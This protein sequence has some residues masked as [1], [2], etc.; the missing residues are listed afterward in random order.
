MSLYIKPIEDKKSSPEYHRHKTTT[1]IYDSLSSFL[2]PNIFWWAFRV[3]NSDE[4]AKTWKSFFIDYE[5]FQPEKTF[6][7]EGG[8]KLFILLPFTVTNN[9]VDLPKH[10]IYCDKK[11]FMMSVHV[12]TITNCYTKCCSSFLLLRVGVCVSTMETERENVFF[13]N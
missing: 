1:I 11:K 9:F 6:M 2:S 12:D 3:W 7:M 5:A 10:H 4:K 13:L 8:K